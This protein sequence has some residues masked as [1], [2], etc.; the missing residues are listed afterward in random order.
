ML[1]SIFPMRRVKIK[2]TDIELM[3]ATEETNC[4]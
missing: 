1:F 3:Y 4:A 2:N